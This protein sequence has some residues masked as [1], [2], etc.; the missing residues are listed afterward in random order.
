MLDEPEAGL[1]SAGRAALR[2]AVA[3]AARRGGA[4]VL[5]VTHDP[6]PWRGVL[7]GV[8]RIGADGAWRAE[9]AAEAGTAA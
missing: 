6:A 9:R 5:L 2:A 7:D 1:D 8:L 3:T 4:A